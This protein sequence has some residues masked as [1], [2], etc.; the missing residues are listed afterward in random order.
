MEDNSVN[1]TNSNN[2][3]DLAEMLMEVYELT[4]SLSVCEAVRVFDAVIILR[5]GDSYKGCRD[6]KNV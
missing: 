6:G 4:P 1:T 5:D 3:P 2:Q